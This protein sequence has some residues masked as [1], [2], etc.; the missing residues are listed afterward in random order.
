MKYSNDVVQ[1]CTVAGRKFWC[2]IQGV[3]RSVL[4]KLQRVEVDYRVSEFHLSKLKELLGIN[5][6]VIF[7]NTCI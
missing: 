6:R 5:P 1:T 2:I 3:S 7:Y 4:V